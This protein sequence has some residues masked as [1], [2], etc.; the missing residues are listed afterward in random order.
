MT[1]TVPEL[2]GSKAL[3][4][5]DSPAHHN[6]TPP[7]PLP[8][9]LDIPFVGTPPVGHP[10]S[11]FFVNPMQKKWDCFPSGTLSDLCYKWTHV[12]SQEVEVRNKHST[13]QGK[14]DTPTLASEARPSSVPQGQEPTS[15]P[16]SPTKATTDPDHGTVSGT[17][18]S[19]RDQDSESNTNHSG[20]S[21]D[22]KASRENVANS[23]MELASRDCFMCLD[24]DEITIRTTCKKY[25][26]RVWA[27]CSLDKGSLWCEAQFK[28]ISDSCQAMWGHD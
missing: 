13:V 12:N 2:E 3:D 20:T 7:T 24:T 27:S 1:T 25:R 16:S 6:G 4:P 9:L 18:R 28:W 10:I 21:S 5:S 22:S 23:D 11:R 17:S 14:E 15:P 26:K 19:T 8:P